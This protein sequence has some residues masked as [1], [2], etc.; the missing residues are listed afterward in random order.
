MPGSKVMKINKKYCLCEKRLKEI[1]KD[2]VIGSK[3]HFFNSVTSTFDEIL[4]FEE[5]EGL[6]VVAA[7]QTKGS[8]RLGRIWESNTGGIYFSFMLKNIN[9]SVDAPFITLICALAVQ[10]ALSEYISCE[11]KWPNDVVSNGKK[12]CGILTKSSLCD[13]KIKNILVGIGVNA[14]NSFSS[15]L[16]YATSLKQLTGK[17]IDEN[18]LL[19]KILKELDICY[20]EK[21]R[22]EVLE[23]YTKA[24]VNIG[25]KVTIHYTNGLSDVVGVCDDILFD[26]TMNVICENGKTLNVNSGEVSVKGIYESERTEK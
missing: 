20:Y 23:E 3:L 10:R 24:C 21:S 11:I 9:N 6:T 8:G 14:N 18:E 13:G 7:H 5:S 22:K 19:Y 15:E 25:R 2:T 4:K 16:V 12:L 17:D 1:V 26:G